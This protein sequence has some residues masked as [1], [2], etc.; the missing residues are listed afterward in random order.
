L[1]GQDDASLGSLQDEFAFHG[2]QRSQH[3]HEEP[4]DRGCRIN[5]L[6]QADEL[7]TANFDLLDDLEKMK[8]GPREPIEGVHV[9]AIVRPQEI[10]NTTKFGTIT[11]Y[12]RGGLP[13]HVAIINA[14]P[15][16]RIKLDGPILRR[17]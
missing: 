11:L 14:R 10:E 3:A 2:G 17:S 7:G 9:Q 8:L 13:E 4:P 16:Q 5:V 15:Y 12:A 6:A 1:L